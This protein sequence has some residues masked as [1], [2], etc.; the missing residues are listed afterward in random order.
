MAPIV[1]LL[2]LFVFVALA[3][4]SQFTHLTKSQDADEKYT[5]AMRYFHKKDY[6]HSGMLFQDLLPLLKGSL[7]ADTAQ[8]YYAYCQFYEKQ[9]TLAA[10][11]FKTYYETFPRNGFAEE[12]AYM[13]GLSYFEDS[14]R[15]DLDQETTR[16]AMRVIQAFLTQYPESERKEDCNFMVEKLRAKLEKKNYDNA[17]IYYHKGDYQAAI[18]AFENFRKEFPESG[19]IELTQ[20]LRVEAAYN[21]ARQSI[22]SKQEQRY[23]QVIATYEALLERYP[24]SKRLKDVEG[25]YAAAQAW[26]D[27]KKGI[28]PDAKTSALE[29]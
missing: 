29:R 6:Y 16:D 25:F 23:G 2:I 22:P 7:R 13:E 18:I 27:E 10:F 17:Y 24:N 4:C 11:Y 26:L 1:R 14:P 12:A 8:L 3:A 20:T 28:K 5:G 19:L 15:Y 9:Y 21:L